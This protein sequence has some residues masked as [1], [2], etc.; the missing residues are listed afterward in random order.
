MRQHPEHWVTSLLV[1]RLRLSPKFG[2]SPK[3]SQKVRS[4]FLLDLGAVQKGFLQKFG[5]F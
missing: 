3:L 2:L 5:N 4:I 1:F